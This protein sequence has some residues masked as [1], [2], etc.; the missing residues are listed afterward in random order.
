MDSLKFL[1]LHFIVNRPSHFAEKINILPSSLILAL[2]PFM[3][4]SNQFAKYL[5]YWPHP[6][7]KFD[8]CVTRKCI[9][10]IVHSLRHHTSEITTFHVTC[11]HEFCATPSGRSDALRDKQLRHL[12]SLAVDLCLLPSPDTSDSDSDIFWYRPV[13]FKVCF[14]V[15]LT[16][17]VSE[18]L[19]WESRIHPSINN[20]P[21]V[22]LVSVKCPRSYHISEFNLFQPLYIQSL[23][24]ESAGDDQQTK[25]MSRRVLKCIGRLSNLVHLNFPSISIDFDNYFSIQNSIS[26][27]QN[28]TSLDIS[29]NGINHQMLMI[30][31]SSLSSDIKILELSNMRINVDVL[32][33]FQASQH[34][35]NIINLRIFMAL[36]PD[37]NDHI[38]SLGAFLMSNKSSLKSLQLGINYLSLDNHQYLLDYVYRSFECIESLKIFEER[39]VI[40]VSII[41]SE[42]N[43]LT[44]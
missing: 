13:N 29:N 24:F 28:L 1:C 3:S 35:K 11:D 44:G 4:T 33:S 23:S 9:N 22:C 16:N 27:L 15:F 42:C 36:D 40:D 5:R 37:I 43:K 17:K 10:T 19:R 39:C 32:E 26:S 8:I 20:H 21:K 18:A 7:F 41:Q 14:T 34:L 6:T 25:I 30:L 38:N 31:F 12:E 2:C